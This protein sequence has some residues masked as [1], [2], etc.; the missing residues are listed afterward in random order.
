MADTN[1]NP[2]ELP[3][4]AAGQSPQGESKPNEEQSEGTEKEQ[5][6][7]EAKE[8][9]SETSDTGEGKSQESNQE[10]QPEA[11]EGEEEEE[12][13]F[14]DPNKV[15]KELKPV[16]K[17]MQA[18]YVRKTQKVAGLRRDYED[19]LANLDKSPDNTQGTGQ[20]EKS[21]TDEVLAAHGIDPNA[22]D[23]NQKSF[24]GL[25]EEIAERKARKITERSVK[26]LYQKNVKD[27]VESYFKAKPQAAKY[28]KAMAEIDDRT[29]EKLTLDELY[30]LASR[31]DRE[32]E[33]RD[34]ESERAAQ[35]RLNNTESSGS[36]ATGAPAGNDPF[37][38]MVQ[39]S[40]EH[41]LPF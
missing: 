24:L 29:G 17:Q 26:P 14:F 37:K 5:T 39:D 11:K 40:Q 3:A 8:S 12:G 35:K 13:T 4:E 10:N 6:N 31:K 41:K 2:N 7:P 21:T 33:N 36:S 9:S 1:S 15:P 27:E 38:K 28:R 19:K 20:A 25:V 22:L 34:K 23:Q 16:Y 32:F 18:D 30:E